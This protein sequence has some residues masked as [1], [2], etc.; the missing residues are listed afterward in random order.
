LG[1]ARKHRQ[2]QSQERE[3]VPLPPGLDQLLMFA[4]S[5]IRDVTGINLELLG[6][7]D[8]EQAAF[9]RSSAAKAP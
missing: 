9:L 8:R 1:E 6:Q 4:I 7:A 5:S 3:S 2:E